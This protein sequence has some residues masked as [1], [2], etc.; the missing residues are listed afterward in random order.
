LSGRD[1]F[2]TALKAIMARKREEL[3]GA[4]TPEELLAYRDGRLDA[5]ARESV[6]ARMAI[7]PDAARALADLAAFPDVEPGPETPELPD[8]DIESRWQSFRPQLEA[9]P[10]PVPALRHRP[11]SWRSPSLAAAAVLLLATGLGLGYLAGRTSPPEPALRP[12]LNPTITELE[13]VGEDEARAAPAPVEMLPGSEE[14]VLVLALP[15]TP[16]F[17]SYA[18]EIVD[19][20]GRSLWSGEGLHSTPL[21]TVQLSFPRATLGP[22]SYRIELSGLE[23]GR[24]EGV[25]R[26]EVRVE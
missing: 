3:G 11:L 12:A 8:G 21:G 2:A 9:L 19:A 4:P 1:D 5:A 10:R 26:Y 22:G 13:P 16:V 23:A 6:E 20:E 7:H 17:S 25:G 24:R 15:A 18:A 14:L